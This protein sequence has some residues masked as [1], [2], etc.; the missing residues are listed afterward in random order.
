MLYIH[1]TIIITNYS[2]YVHKGRMRK[3]NTFQLINIDFTIEKELGV[4]VIH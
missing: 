4:F 2:V 3:L 1:P